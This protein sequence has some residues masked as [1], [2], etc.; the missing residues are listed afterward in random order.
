MLKALPQGP[1]VTL[2]ADRDYDTEDFVARWSRPGRDAARGAEHDESLKPDRWPRD[3]PLPPALRRP[4]P[5]VGGLEPGCASRAANSA[6]CRRK[7]P[8]TCSRSGTSPNRRP[9]SSTVLPHAS[10][11]RPHRQAGA[12]RPRLHAL[13]AYLSCRGHLGAAVAL[14][15]PHRRGALRARWPRVPARLQPGSPPPSRWRARLRQGR[16]ARRGDP[17][18]RAGGGSLPPPQPG[19]RRG[20]PG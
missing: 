7:S 10:R 20:L 9:S 12:C 5:F 15:E 8:S 1:R 17:G 14:R 2:G 4:T 13:E 11:P 3:A 19:R 6:G 16:L 18:G